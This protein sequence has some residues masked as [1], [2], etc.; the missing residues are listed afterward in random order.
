MS[1]ATSNAIEI[2]IEQWQFT[3]TIILFGHN[4]I[5]FIFIYLFYL[6][7]YCLKLINSEVKKKVNKNNLKNKIKYNTHLLYDPEIKAKIETRNANE[8]F[9]PQHSFSLKHSVNCRG[10]IQ[11]IRVTDRDVYF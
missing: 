9:C 4:Y 6:F 5:K 10:Y 11:N 7:I 8:F 3:V 1:K 2:A